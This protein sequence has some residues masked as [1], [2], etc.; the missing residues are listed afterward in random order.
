MTDRKKP[1]VAFRATVA[2]IAL[3]A[4][5]LSFGPACWITARSQLGD[6]IGRACMEEVYRPVLWT[7]AYGPAVIEKPLFWWGEFGIRDGGV[8]LFSIDESPKGFVWFGLPQ[9]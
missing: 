5:P 1:G 4:Y 7:I 3:L 8:A 2:L 9:R 6:Q